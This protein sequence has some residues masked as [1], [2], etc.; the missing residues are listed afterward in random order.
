MGRSIRTDRW[1][2]SE[3]DEGRA[4]VELYDHNQDPQEFTNLAE[5]PKFKSVIDQLR[6]Q[7]K[8]HTRGAVPSAPFNPK[9]L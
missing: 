2:Y 7:F 8:D 1:R 4:G 5:D 6:L 9:R 3:W